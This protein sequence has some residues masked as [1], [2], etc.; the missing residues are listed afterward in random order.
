[1]RY[2]INFSYDGSNYNGYQFQPNLKT[3]QNELENA[4]EIVNNGIRKTVQASGITDKGVHALSQYAHVDL[5]ISIEP[6]KLKRALNS[7]L[8]DDIHIIK[9]EIVDDKFHARYGVKSK[10]YKYYIN[11]G[12]YNPIEKNYV[13]QY[14]YKLDYSSMSDAIDV[15][16]GEHD[17]RAFVTE[18]TNKPNCVR[19]IDVANI[20]LKND[21]LIFTFKGNGFMRYQ[22]RN[23]V[24]SLIKLGEGKINKEDLQKLLESKDRSKGCATAPSMGLYLVNVEY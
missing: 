16:L 3:I 19:R 7:N 8:P 6:Y 23:M 22:I 21:K 1:M 9:T 14:N 2:L 15:F 12:E 24:G 10:E 18:N 5:D 11:L 17:F 4:V 13:F 20:E